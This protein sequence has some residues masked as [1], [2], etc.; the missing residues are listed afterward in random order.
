ME[1][2]LNTKQGFWIQWISGQ[3]SFGYDTYDKNPVIFDILPDYSEGKIPAGNFNLKTDVFADE[4]M[5]QTDYEPSQ[6][7]DYLDFSLWNQSDVKGS[8]YVDQNCLEG[9]NFRELPPHDPEWSKVVVYKDQMLFLKPDKDQY[10]FNAKVVK[11]NEESIFIQANL[12]IS[13][14]LKNET[15]YLIAMPIHHQNGATR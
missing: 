15:E 13:I 2:K 3:I 8:F 1:L 9:T 4:I 11:V 14:Q 6:L 12:F 5:K 10:N 7:I